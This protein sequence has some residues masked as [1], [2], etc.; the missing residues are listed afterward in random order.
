MGGGSGN[1][2]WGWTDSTT[3]REYALM[4]LTDGTAFV[5]VSTPAS[6]VFLGRLPSQTFAS[7]WRDIKVYDDH[8][9]IVADAAGAHGMQVFDLTRLRGRSVPK[10]FTAD[11]VYDDFKESHNLAINADTGFAYAVSTN[12]CGGGLHMIN[13]G[14]PDDPR[15]AGCHSGVQTHDTQCVLYK[16]ADTE[17]H[18]REVCFS[19]NGN[20]LEVV[21]VTDK[22]DPESLSS[23]TYWQ[24]A[25][26]HQGWLTEDHRFFLL[27]DELD[28]RGFAVPTRTHVFDMADLDAPKYLYAHEHGTRSIDHN[29]FVRGNRVFEAN[30]ASGLRVLKFG[31]LIKKDIAEVAYFDTFPENDNAQ[32]VGAWSVYPYLPSGTVLVSDISRGLFVLSMD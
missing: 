20:H 10:T 13:I 3:S 26:V 31:N 17:H 16:G 19:S 9:Y 25:Y 28:E 29:L 6:P 7:T 24:L 5:D 2:L 8:A 22:S 30:Y 12:T 27:G 15:F 21:D 32:F 4:G 11:V 23:T 14:T 1:D 18:G